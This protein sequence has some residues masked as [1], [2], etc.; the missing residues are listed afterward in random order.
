M[1]IGEIDSSA[2]SSDSTRSFFASFYVFSL[3]ETRSG[4]VGPLTQLQ[5][6]LIRFLQ[7]EFNDGQDMT[8]EETFEARRVT[9]YTIIIS[10]LHARTD[11]LRK[12]DGCLERVHNGISGTAHKG[13]DTVTLRAYLLLFIIID[14]HDVSSRY[15]SSTYNNE[16]TQ[17][18]RSSSRDHYLCRTR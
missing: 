6:N 14:R 1:Y 5:P 11:C 16:R 2:G 13:G 8:A 18:T 3:F 7:N 4:D 10:K 15:I 17:K 12:N 9:A